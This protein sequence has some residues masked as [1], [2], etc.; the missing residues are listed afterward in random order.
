MDQVRELGE[1]KFSDVHPDSLA[2]KLLV[3]NAPKLSNRSHLSARTKPLSILILNPV[4]L[5]NTRT[6]V[7]ETIAGPHLAGGESALVL[8]LVI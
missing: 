3:A 8:T 2:G 7:V 4:D 5:L 1:D 6:V